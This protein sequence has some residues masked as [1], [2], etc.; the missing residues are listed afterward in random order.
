VRI[1]GVSLESYVSAEGNSLCLSAR[2]FLLEGSYEAQIIPRD[3]A[4]NIGEKTTFYLMVDTTLPHLSA[5]ATNE[6]G[7]IIVQGTVNDKNPGRVKIYNNGLKVDEYADSSASFTRNIRAFSGSNALVVEAVDQ[8]GNKTS[9]ALEPI[10]NNQAAGGLITDFCQG[11]NPFNPAKKLTGAFSAHGCG[12][13]FSFALAKPAD[14]KIRIYDITG[15]LIWCRDIP[16]AAS[17]VTAW[18]GVDQFG[19]FTDNGIYPYIFSAAA[20]GANDSRKGKIVIIK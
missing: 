7:N 17:G 11:P 3:R 9:A 6:G 12:T 4:G 16:A 19:G 8:A 20:D 2:N 10:F 15:T 13:V 1:A 14:V 5:S 18:S